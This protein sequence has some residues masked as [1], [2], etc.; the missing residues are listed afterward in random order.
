MIEAL[1]L[2]A[3]VGDKNCVNDCG[4]CISKMTPD[5]YV[6]QGKTDIDLIEFRRALQAASVFSA[7]YFLIT[8][9]GEPTIY[10][11]TIE[12]L[13][14]E[15]QIIPFIRRELQT[16]GNLIAT[17]GEKYDSFL[18][19]WRKKGLDVVAV[20]IYHHNDEINKRMF[21]P[22]SGSFY[23]LSELIEKIHSRDLRVRLSC[24]MLK[25]CIDS[26][27]QVQGL[28]EYA[29]ENGVFQLTLR[30]ADT[31]SRPVDSELSRRTIEYTQGNMLDEEQLREISSF[32]ESTGRIC[33]KL[34][35]GAV[36]Y[37]VDKQNVCITTG[38]TDDVEQ[39]EKRTTDAGEYK[40]RQLIFFAPNILTS[41][42]EN[43]FGG[44]IR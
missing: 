28:I 18:S 38:L 8:G 21:R 34:P 9:K 39:N 42:W 43:P 22:K 25:D 5:D 17:G 27:E 6:S 44:R 35:H 1:T 7:K 4:I 13:L 12:E 23:N 20:S 36:I 30:T 14:D 29:K 26:P 11:E 15:S 3:V 41:S 19:S 24:V 37:E 40:I 2:T 16:A 32:L 33:G 31:P 10:P